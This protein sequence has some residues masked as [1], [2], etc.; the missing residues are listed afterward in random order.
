[1]QHVVCIHEP[2]ASVG[3]WGMH[4]GAGTYAARSGAVSPGHAGEDNLGQELHNRELYLGSA[5]RNQEVVFK[6]GK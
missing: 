1:V 4:G 3:S 6:D 5:R 2:Q